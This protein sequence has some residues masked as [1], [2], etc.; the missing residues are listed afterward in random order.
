MKYEVRKIN[1]MGETVATTETDSKSKANGVA[2]AWF[3]NKDEHEDVRIY[4]IR[5]GY[6]VRIY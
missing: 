3:L 2:T 6:K 5:E 4:E 1:W